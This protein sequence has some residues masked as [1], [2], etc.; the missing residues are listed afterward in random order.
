[1]PSSKHLAALIAGHHERQARDW[2]A[3]RRALPWVDRP[4]IDLFASLLAAGG[5]V[6]DLGCGGGDPVATALAVERLKVTGVNPPRA[7]ILLCR[8]RMSGQQWIAGNMQFR[9][10]PVSTPSSPGTIS[11][12]EAPTIRLPC[13]RSSPRARR[14]VACMFSAGPARGEATGFYRGDPLYHASLDAADMS[15]CCTAPTSICW[16]ISSATS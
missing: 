3:D 10:T 15:A 7:L 16:S 4:W 14:L 8:E 6:L 12:T 11:L 5:A 13:C 2:G 1:M 9:S